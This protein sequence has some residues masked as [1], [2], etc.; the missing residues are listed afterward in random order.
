MQHRK[1]TID[2]VVREENPATAVWL[3][4][5]GTGGIKLM[6]AKGCISLATTQTPVRSTVSP[7]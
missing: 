7:H 1:H 2:S 3:K 4:D 5:I 6:H